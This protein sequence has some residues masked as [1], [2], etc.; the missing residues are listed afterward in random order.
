VP[1][2]PEI[3]LAPALVAAATLAARRWDERVGGLVSAFPAIAGPVL[4]IDVHEH[5]TAFAARAATGTVLGL[6]TLSGFALVYGLAARRRPWGWSLAAGWA[7]AAVLAAVAGALHAG[8]GAACA[9]AGAS[10][11]A[12]YVGLGRGD[13]A[14]EAVPATRWDLPL[15]MVLTA[16]LVGLLAALAGWVGPEVGGVLTALPVLASILAVFTHRR[17][18]AQGVTDLLRGMVAG[19]VGFAVFCATLALLVDRAAVVAAFGVAALAGLLVQ[20]AALL[21]VRPAYPAAAGGPLP[22]RSPA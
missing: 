22:D 14:A 15:R 16:A 21:T 1:L 12:A 19:M 20:A 8:L 13:P 11:L 18:G 5:G 10:L 9:V 7:A 6:L 3:L 4:L 17:L 2:T